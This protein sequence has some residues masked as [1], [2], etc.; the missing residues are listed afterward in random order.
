MIAE[1]L[2]GDPIA[3]VHLETLNEEEASLHLDVLLQG[4][5][6]ATIVDLCNQILHL[7]AVERSQADQQLVEHHAQCPGVHLLVVAALLEK[8]GARVE[9]GTTYTEVCVRSVEDR[10]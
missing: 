10:R 7:V 8:L 5:L 4:D 3:F 6:V 9:R 2:D 1:L